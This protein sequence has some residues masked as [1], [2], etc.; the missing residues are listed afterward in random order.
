MLGADVQD[1]EKAKQRQFSKLESGRCFV[2]SRAKI[3]NH[4]PDAP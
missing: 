1:A 4:T 3:K 2:A